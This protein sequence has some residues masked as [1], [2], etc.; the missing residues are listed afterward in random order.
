MRLQATSGTRAL[1]QVNADLTIRRDRTSD[2]GQVAVSSGAQI[3][4]SILA[5][6][7]HRDVPN[8]RLTGRSNI[9]ELVAVTAVGRAREVRVW[10]S[11]DKGE[12]RNVPER[13]RGEAA[14][15]RA[16]IPCATCSVAKVVV[17]L[18]A[19]GNCIGA[20]SER[21]NE[22]DGESVELEHCDSLA[23]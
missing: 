4:E 18:K 12:G 22:N 9:G 5:I 11:D 2:A 23:K 19:E 3:D 17:S 10:K 8:P 14:R 20:Q 21:C 13:G 6:V 15:A 7:D 16:G 1:L